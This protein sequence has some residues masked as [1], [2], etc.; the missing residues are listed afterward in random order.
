MNWMDEAKKF[1]PGLKVLALHGAGR[2]AL[3]SKIPDHDL[4]VTS[5]ALLRRD[6]AEY[7]KME[8]PICY[9]TMVTGL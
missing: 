4:V 9:V 7:E 8:F 5:Y 2:K 1:A 6:I 3:I